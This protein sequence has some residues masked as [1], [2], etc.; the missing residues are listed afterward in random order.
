VRAVATR[1]LGSPDLY[2]HEEREAEQ[3]I[4]FVTCHDGFTL[5]DLVS[6]NH[7]HNEANGESNRDGSDDNLSWNCGVEGPTD[8]PNIEEL[9]N[10]QVKNFLAL[11]L[12]AVGTPML[13]MG[14]E[15]RRT[16]RG[17]NNA[18]CQD[19]D[20]SWMDWTLLERHR[21]IHRFVKTLNGF[22][23]RRDV[24]V[25][26]TAVSLNELL[27]RARI[28]WHGVALRHP[29][30]S[31]PSHSLAFTLRS[32]HGRFLLHGMLNAYWEPLTFELPPVPVDHQQGW[33][34]RCID[35]ALDSPDDICPW[36]TAPVVSQMTYVAQ[37]RSVVLLALAFETSPEGFH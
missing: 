11:E 8:N 18:Y 12:L 28:E 21:D 19:S 1:I 16:Q 9:R 31:D 29:D 34:R 22:R 14:D 37:P 24:V 36:E 6:Y 26:G 35:T 15:V 33:W 30:W 32:P 2:G 5:N 3:S 20:I 17:N 4:N 7:K 10:R 25:K 13:L 23:Q 27:C